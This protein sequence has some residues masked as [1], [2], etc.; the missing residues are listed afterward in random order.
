MDALLPSHVSDLHGW[1]RCRSGRAARARDAQPVG[2]VQAGKDPRFETAKL[3]WLKQLGDAEM[4]VLEDP[5]K[6]YGRMGTGDLPPGAKVIA[7]GDFARD[8]RAEYLKEYKTITKDV[9]NEL[10]HM[11]DRF[12]PSKGVIVK[13]D[14]RSIGK[15]FVSTHYAWYPSREVPLRDI[16][17]LTRLKGHLQNGQW[18]TKFRK[19]LRKD[20]MTRDMLLVEVPKE[21]QQTYVRVMPT[22]PP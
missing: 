11:E 7:F 5:Q 4:S 6:N 15:G 21:K 8:L 2:P 10:A 16:K 22:S 9:E 14:P 17:G 12:Q 19:V 20:E 1:L 13:Y 3:E 18:L